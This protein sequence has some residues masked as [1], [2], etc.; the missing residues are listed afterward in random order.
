V[1]A[2]EREDSEFRSLS[3][4]LRS[5]EDG[6]FSER[7]GTLEPR[8]TVLQ[9][10]TITFVSGTEVPNDQMVKLKTFAGLISPD[11]SLR[12][13]I[14]GCSDPSGSEAVNRKVSKARAESVA[15]QLR[16]LGVSGEQIGHVVGRGEDCEVQERAV[17]ITPV[18][19][20]ETGAAR[21][22]NGDRP[23]A[24]R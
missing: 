24:A 14:V 8:T 10:I 11:A 9:A 21:Q 7:A 17:H 16:S 2:P 6:T 3:D 4:L 5:I 1:P 23:S 15:S 19:H 20:E 13:E 18:F 22:D 12:I